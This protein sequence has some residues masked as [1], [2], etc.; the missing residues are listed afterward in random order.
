M[1]I[2]K[3]GKIIYRRWINGWVRGYTEGIVEGGGEGAQTEFCMPCK[4]GSL[5]KHF[6]LGCNN[7][8]VISI[9]LN[10]A[11][12]P[13]SVFSDNIMPTFRLAF[14]Y[15]QFT[16][17]NETIKIYI[18]FSRSCFCWKHFITFLFSICPMLIFSLYTIK[19]A[20]QTLV[21]ELS[22]TDLPLRNDAP[23]GSQQRIKHLLRSNFS[24]LWSER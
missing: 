14:A 6:C 12:A 4:K 15:T 1:E 11:R 23:P 22:P 16:L 5:T 19:T 8:F 17:P 3:F 20:T 18:Y 2:P 13:G 21:D 24:N 10:N 7:I 9:T